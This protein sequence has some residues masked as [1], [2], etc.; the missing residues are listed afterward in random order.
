VT[1]PV[2]TAVS[3]VARVC[4]GIRW[5]FGSVLGDDA[6]RRYV[7]HLR[8]AHPDAPVPDERAFWRQRYA[9]EDANP[10]ARCC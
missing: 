4:R 5:W 2:V 6:Y 7:E 8:R 3:G 10:G 9:E 1:G